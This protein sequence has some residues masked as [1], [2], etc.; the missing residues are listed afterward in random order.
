MQQLFQALCDIADLALGCDHCQRGT[1]QDAS[2]VG[3]LGGGIVYLWSPRTELHVGVLAAPQGRRALAGRLLGKSSA[4]E[5]S[6]SMVRGAMCELA[7]LLAGGVRRRLLGAGAVSV[8][9]PSFLEG[10][11]QPP[12]G[13]TV[14]VTPVMLD[15]VE[16]TLV[17]VT[18]NVAA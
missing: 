17:S 2:S 5:L 1:E 13:W 14:Q 12:F 6:E 8:G 15:D 9:S 10:T 7:Y 11:V 16:A 4:D 3:G 18:R